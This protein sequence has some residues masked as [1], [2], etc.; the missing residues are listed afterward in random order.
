M[1]KK[2]LV[3]LFFLLIFLG[4]VIRNYHLKNVFF[5]DWDEGMYAQIAREILKNKSLVTTFN[6][7]LWFDKPPLSHLLIGISF[8]IFGESHFFSRLIMVFLALLLLVLTF[9]LTKKIT[10]SSTASLL[11]VLAL[12]STS[13]FIE[14][15]TMLN[16]DLLVAISW[17]GYF[18]F[19]ENYWLKLIFLIIGVL[20]KSVLGFYPLLFEGI[21][22]LLNWKKIK[23][24]N[25]VKLGLFLLSPLLW[26]F[27]G[28][29]KFGQQFIY[30]HF[31]SQMFKRIY[32]PIELHFGNKFFYFTALWQNLSVISLLI[33]F[34]Y[35]LLFK[36]LKK[37]IKNLKNLLIMISPLPFLFFLTI[38]RTKIDWYLIIFLPLLIILIAYFYTK[39][40]YQRLR[41]MVF[42]FIIFFFLFKFLPKT[43]FLKVAYQIPEKLILAQCLSKTNNKNFILLV[44]D[45]ERKNRNFLEAAHY[46]TTSSFYYGG[47][48]SFVFYLN[49]PIEFY[50]DQKKFLENYLKY[51]VII[52]S[53]KDFKDLKKEIGYKKLVCQ[54][55]NWLSLTW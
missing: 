3:G 55:D 16:S 6:G 19:W 20:S 39:I 48:P 13:I 37:E 24:I 2:W 11:T 28:I 43:F 21:Y 35:L 53:K 7:Q 29:F 49:K 22:Y 15:S 44:D 18:L 30:H 45:Q 40:H 54:T 52:L 47:S 23:K 27:F 31:L 46:E 14:R 51:Q 50:Y 5:Y 1:K 26:Y 4:L 34:G 17:L 9:F 33:I 42:I 10:N 12:S 8:F 25:F 32:V 38:M 41:K 36:N